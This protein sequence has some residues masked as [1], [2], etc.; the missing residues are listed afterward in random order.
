MA[1][2]GAVACQ[3]AAIG[4]QRVAQRRASRPAAVPAAAPCRRRQQQRRLAVAATAAP[5]A[6]G[7]PFAAV[8]NEEQLFCLLKAGASSGTV[9]PRIIA[10]FNELY[11]NYKA[12]IL[13]GGAPGASPDFVAKVMASVCERVLLE[14]NPSTSY[15][16]P[17]YHAAIKAPY[18]YFAFGQRYI[19]GLIDF[20]N[21]VLGHADRFEQIQKQLDAGENVVLI[22]NHQS[23]ADPAVFALLLEKAFPRLAEQVIYVAGDRVVTDALCKPFSMGRNLFCVHSKKHIDDIPELKAE[24]QAMNRRTLKAMQSALNEGGKLLWIAP[25]GGRD[26]R[27]DPVTDDFMPDEFDP[28]AVELMRALATKA[29]QPGHIYPFT[30]YSYKIMPPP[31]VV[32]KAIGEKRVIAHAPVGISVCPELD[33]EAVLAGIEDKEQRQ[34]KLAQQSFEE[35]CAEYDRMRAAIRDPAS[36]EAAGF[37][38]PWL[39]SEPVPL[40]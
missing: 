32:E 23:E 27:I 1:T 16:F 28:S 2:S 11:A 20:K 29:K 17:S 8:Q 10:A 19:R 26:R 3:A 13:E 31:R 34:A 37:T 39:A 30:M 22:A 15:T 33:V 21:S 35:V 4:A 6:T 5:P 25:S 38:Q 24:K 36:R 18:D 14:L 9:P 40:E 7:S 12:A